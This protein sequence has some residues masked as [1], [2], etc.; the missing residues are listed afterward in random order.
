[1]IIDLRI[2]MSEIGKRITTQLSIASTKLK[3]LVQFAYFVRFSRKYTKLFY[4]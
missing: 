3:N 1:M 4:L 2:I